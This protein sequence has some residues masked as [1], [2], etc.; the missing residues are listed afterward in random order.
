MLYINY[1]WTGDGEKSLY[2]LEWVLGTTFY[3]PM[4]ETILLSRE[5][6]EI[7]ILIRMRAT[8]IVRQILI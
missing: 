7:K 8:S 5:T 4:G 2:Q 3:E 6:P 1:T